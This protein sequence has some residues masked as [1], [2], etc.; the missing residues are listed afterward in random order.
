MTNRRSLTGAGIAVA[1]TMA[2]AGVA[3]ADDVADKAQLE[4]RVQELERELAEV[5]AAVRGGYFTAG[6]D[7]EARVSELERAS[8]DNS[9]TSVFKAGMKSS[10][11]DGA[12]QYQWFGLIQ[13][14]W[15]WFW[16]EGGDHSPFVN[17]GFGFRRIRL[18]ANGTMYG[19]VRWHSE[20]NF[21]GGDVTLADM[22]IELAHCAFGNIRVGHMKEPIGFDQITS[23]RYVQFMERSTVN[24]LSPV[25]NTGVMLH[26]TCMEES[27]L[28]QIGMFRDANSAGDDF[29]NA[30]A[31]EYD[32]AARLSTR[33][34]VQDDGTTWLHL[35]ASGR[36]SDYA[37][38]VIGAAA[39]PAIFTAPALISGVAG[40]EDGWQFGLEAAY[41]TGPWTFLGEYCNVNND[42]IG[43]VDADA[44]A[45]SLEGAY[46]LTGEN[47][48]YDKS[49]GT[50]GR[51]SPKQNFGDG[52]GRGAWQVAVRYDTIDL[53][54][55]GDMDRWTFGVK[56]WLNPNTAV[57]LNVSRADPDN[58]LIVSDD[59]LTAIGMRFEIDF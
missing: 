36:W 33:T 31:G 53:G 39:G 57:H 9:M 25:R 23:D 29:G 27:L 8:A 55:A 48:A 13:N 3:R 22:W 58:S 49:K 2:V 41:V 40:A 7:L 42:A 38:D 18:G 52:E 46:W 45:W 15:V 32:F 4:N 16:D 1:L 50:F 28:Y 26:G 30:K 5:K 51:T 56:W 11:G 44:D 34:M 35:G 47:T 17:P 43:S 21:S 6:S 20:L 59:P 24:S 37:D 14:D 12:F 10:G 19:N 54:D